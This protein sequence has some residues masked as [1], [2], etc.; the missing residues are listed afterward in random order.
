MRRI[1]IKE[2]PLVFLRNVLVMEIVAAISLYAL[3]FLGNYEKLYQNWGI[4]SYVRYD[5]FLILV[6]CIFETI[7]ISLLFLDWYFTH[8]EI[9]E[10]EITKKSGLLFRHRK[11]VDLTKVV[12]I[13][14][15]NSPVGRLMKHATI[16]L[17]HENDRVTKLK[18][19]S[20]ADEFA[21]I[22]KQMVKKGDG[23]SMFRS[24]SSV[25]EEGE[26]LTVEF[27]ETLRF[28][29]RK[30]EISKE[31]ERA[32]LKTVVA[33][34]NTEGGTLLIGVND[35]GEITGLENDFKTLIKKNRD[36]FEN[37]LSMLVKTMIGL[38]FAKYVHA[39]F[40]KINDKE[41]CMVSVSKNHKPAYFKGTD[42]EEFFVRV[43][44]STQPFSMSETEEYIATHWK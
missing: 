2:G 7:Y 39:K 16:I 18:N 21:H 29:I 41:V 43:G 9:T 17:H 11:S 22:I 14:T 27:K 32:V 10:T 40:E 26:G 24:I 13:E 20:S 1:I 4:V 36:G 8:F 6:F 5:I 42:K 19:I 23:N 38:S 12:S 28:D 34:M 15:Y 25:I 44:N 3:S 31:M 35:V 30:K 37:H 33:F